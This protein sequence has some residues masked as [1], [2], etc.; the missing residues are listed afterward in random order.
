MFYNTFISERIK[1]E[2]YHEGI[3]L[4]LKKLEVRLIKKTLMQR[5]L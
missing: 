1:G 2:K 5:E 3:I 4:E